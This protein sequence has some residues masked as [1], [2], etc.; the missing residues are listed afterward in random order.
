MDF[1]SLNRAKVALK[2]RSMPNF[3]FSFL[4][5]LNRAKVAL[6]C[7]PIV[8]AFARF[9]ASGLNRAKVALKY[10]SR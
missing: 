6:K 8:E 1:F 7:M 3:S 9:L 5:S 4:N 10:V 2:F